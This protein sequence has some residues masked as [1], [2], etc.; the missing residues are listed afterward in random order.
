MIG[1]QGNLSTMTLPD[2]LQWIGQGQ[3]SGHLSIVRAEQQRA[4][5]THDGDLISVTSND[6]RHDLISVLG[7]RKWLTARQVEL[8]RL[9]PLSCKEP[10]ETILRDLQ[11][12]PAGTLCAV[13]TEVMID[14][15][16]ELFTWPEGAFSF[17]KGV[18]DP[19]AALAQPV[20][21]NQLIMEGCRRL[22]DLERYRAAIPSE[23]CVFRLTE[24]GVQSIAD[25]PEIPLPVLGF[26]DGR[27]SLAEI[28]DLGAYSG[29]SVYAAVFDALRDGL[30]EEVGRDSTY[31]RVRGARALAALAARL[32]GEGDFLRALEAIDQALSLAPDNRESQALRAKIV[33]DKRSEVSA[34]FGMNGVVPYVLTTHTSP[35]FPSNRISPSEGFVLSRIDGHTSITQ[36]QRVCALPREQLIDALYKFLK[37]GIIALR[38]S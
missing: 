35:G 1:I 34:L 15:V 21:V 29:F 10:I 12:V 16:F 9:L 36:L 37:L 25:G 6:P 8:T 33:L 22:D 38:P 27:R 17:H 11:L 20:G 24:R 7:L 2:V 5:Y 19:H 32:H 26:L 14:G 23:E 28:I 3:H 13:A 18:A 31:A 4:L 30:V